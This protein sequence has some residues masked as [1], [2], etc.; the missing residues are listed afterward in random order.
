[1]AWAPTWDMCE[2][3]GVLALLEMCSRP[4]FEA[5]RARKRPSRRVMTEQRD[6]AG[7]DD[8]ASLLWRIASGDRPAFRT[9]YDAQSP[10]LY[11]VA[12]RITRQ[13]ALASD[14]MHDAFLQVWRNASQFDSARGTPE[15]WLLSLVRYR[16]LDIAR[17]RGREVLRDAMPEQVDPDPDALA[18]LV[19]RREAASLHQCLERLEPERRDLVALAFVDG[20]SHSELAER[21]KMPLGTVK[22]WIRRSL[23]ALRACLD[24][25]S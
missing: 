17:N 5:A 3:E 2:A 15:S 12:M 4:P 6:F 25:V 14:A 8:L 24:G 13:P 19:Q 22:S 21:I 10:R 16:A 18:Q 20:L 7:G 9:L 23:I 11:A 1:M